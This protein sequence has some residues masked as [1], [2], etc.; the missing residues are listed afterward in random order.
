[1]DFQSNVI[2]I[3][4][5]KLA[6]FVIEKCASTS[7][8]SA[9]RAALT[10]EGEKWSVTHDRIIRLNPLPWRNQSPRPWKRPDWSEFLSMAFVRHP[11]DRLASTF[12]NKIRPSG[13]LLREHIDWMD[14][15][16]TF[17]QFAREVCR[18]PDAYLDRHLHPQHKRMSI[19]NMPQ[20]IFR[21]ESLKTDWAAAQSLIFDH[22][23]LEVPDLP[24]L[25]KSKSRRYIYREYTAEAVRYRYAMD[26]ELFGYE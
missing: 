25:N 8:K 3:P 14:P 9:L 13:V 20:H 23:G 26:M 21:V 15:K 6:V 5:L 1:M 4:S 17:E 24:Y 19:D 18:R 10:V 7:I 16:M 11:L 22:C 2:V 12:H